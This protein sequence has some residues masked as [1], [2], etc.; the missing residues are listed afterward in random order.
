MLDPA[1]LAKNPRIEGTVFVGEGLKQ[2]VHWSMGKN[3]VVTVGFHSLL[4]L[5]APFAAPLAAETS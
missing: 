4:H 2:K 1:R 3:Y 5:F